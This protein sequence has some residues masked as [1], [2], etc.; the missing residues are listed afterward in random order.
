MHTFLF[1]HSK[2]FHQSLNKPT[3]EQT[4]SVTLLVLGYI[5]ITF[6]IIN[7]I[8]CITVSTI[9]IIIIIT[10][11]TTIIIIKILTANPNCEHKILTQRPWQG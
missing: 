8:F 6:I 4:L 1:F 3:H 5:N 9:I 2:Y 7:N 11:T 10:S